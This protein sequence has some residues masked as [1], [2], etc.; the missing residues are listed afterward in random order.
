M[1]II[2]CDYHPSFQQIAFVETVRVTGLNSTNCADLII[3]LQ[4]NTTLHLGEFHG[5][6]AG[7]VVVSHG[8]DPTAYGVAPH[9]PSIVGLQQFRRRNHVP[10]SRIEPHV[11]AVWVEDDWHTVVDRCS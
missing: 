4:E 6:G 3:P 10:H 9:Q 7:F 2:G 1:I 5:R 8:I 11:V